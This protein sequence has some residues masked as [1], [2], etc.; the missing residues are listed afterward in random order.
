MARISIVATGL[1]STD[2]GS[3]L[4]PLFAISAYVLHHCLKSRLF[5][6][7]LLLFENGK[8]SPEYTNLM[9]P[10]TLIIPLIIFPISIHIRKQIS[11]TIRLKNS[12]D[13]GVFTCRVAVGVVCTVAMI[14]PE[15]VDC[16]GIVWT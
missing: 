1:Q 11:L 3:M 12:S 13:I 2:T 4:V 14:R 6:S 15:A 5:A 9:F 7:I 16:P 10:E 8:K